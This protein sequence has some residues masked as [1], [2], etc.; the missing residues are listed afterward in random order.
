LQGQ[1]KA[2]LIAS[3]PQVLA[4]PMG[5]HTIEDAPA[6]VAAAR[7]LGMTDV[8]PAI[9]GIGWGANQDQQRG[10]PVHVRSFP[11]ERPPQN[12]RS[13]VEL[14]PDV[15]WIYTTPGFAASLSLQPGDPLTVVAPRA[16]LTPFGP[17]PV[18]KQYRIAALSM[19]DESETS[20]DAWLSEDEASRLF[21]TNGEPT[22]I[23]MY[24]PENASERVQTALAQRFPKVQFKTWRE[25]NRPLVLA[26]RLEKIVMFATISLI[27]FV[28]ALNLISSLSM[29]ILEKRPSVGVLRTLGTTEGSIRS[30]FMQVGLLIGVMG[31]ILGNVIGLGVAWAADRFR[32]IPLPSDMYF[33]GYLPFT[34]DVQD[35]VVVNLIA[36]GLSIVATWYPSR[37]AARLDPITA[38]KEE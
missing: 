27:I 20:V 1:I 26:L 22:S 33:I 36:I 5:R 8:R 6:I 7:G 9:R 29:L 30:L 12:L 23:E 15:P 21:G 31:T 14:P 18:W 17:V 4:E 37:I 16:R 28:A 10:R 3:S 34:L 35:V 38:I 11:A 25:I 24:G 32:L 19:P 2:Q 13:R